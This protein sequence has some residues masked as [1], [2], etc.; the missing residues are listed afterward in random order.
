MDGLKEGGQHWREQDR[1]ERWQAAG[2]QINAKR[3]EPLEKLLAQLP[4]DTDLPLRILDIGAGDGRVAA[5]VLER[6]PNASVVLIDFSLPMIRKGEEQLARFGSRYGYHVWDMNEGSWPEALIGPFDAAVSSAAIHHLENPRKAWLAREV[7]ARLRLGGVFA[8]YDLFRDPM[9]T[10]E[11][12]E[13]HDR[14]CAS[15]EEAVNF[16]EQAGYEGIVI[17]A[18]IARP[19]SKGEQAL[20]AARRSR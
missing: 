6:Y 12:H 17:E 1:V 4:S 13:V 7:F 10:F 19:K 9:A 5:L 14:T 16:L 3:K 15:M 8:N 11:A 2:D 20:L 18:R